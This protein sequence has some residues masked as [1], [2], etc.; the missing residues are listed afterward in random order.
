MSVDLRFAIGLLLGIYGGMLV[1]D[2][3]VEHVTVLGL[4]VNLW[5]GAAML[6]FGLALL[7]FVRVR[8]NR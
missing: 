6:A 1:V 5:W 7:A 3:L 2:G 8:R 4:N